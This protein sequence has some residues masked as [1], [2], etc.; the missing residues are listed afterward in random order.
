MEDSI[1]AAFKVATRRVINGILEEV[2]ED[3]FMVGLLNIIKESRTIINMG[4]G[5]LID[6]S[7]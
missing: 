5:A 4:Q 7:E 2:I 6:I 1:K 3:Q